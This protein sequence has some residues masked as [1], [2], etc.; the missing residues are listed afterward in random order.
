MDCGSALAAGIVGGF[1]IV[2]VDLLLK[3][4]RI[5]D[6]VNAFAVHGA[7]GFWGVLAACSAPCMRV[8]APD[9][10]LQLLQDTCV[11]NCCSL[12]SRGD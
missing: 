11:R 10:H 12:R 2:G 5:D 7:C 1:I 8:V 9:E 6:P 4:L 3:S